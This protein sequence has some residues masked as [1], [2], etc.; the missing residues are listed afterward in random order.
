MLHLVDCR[1]HAD[2]GRCAGKRFVEVSLLH[3][4][5]KA[6]DGFEAGCSID[7]KQIRSKTDIWAM[8]NVCT[9]ES[10]MPAAFVGVV[11]EVDVG[12]LREERAR[13]LREGMK[14]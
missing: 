1:V 5:P 11:C 9:V 14:C 6:V 3:I 10:K 13:V 4:G 2:C 8:L 7:G 12:N